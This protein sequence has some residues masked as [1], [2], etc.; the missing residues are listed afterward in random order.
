MDFNYFEVGDVYWEDLEDIVSIM[1]W[2]KNEDWLV[3][4]IFNIFYYCSYL[5]FSDDKGDKE[6]ILKLFVKEFFLMGRKD[7]YVVSCSKLVLDM[8]EVYS[9]V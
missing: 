2:Y 5:F 9:D 4:D 6:M 1:K 8:K 7:G 3:W